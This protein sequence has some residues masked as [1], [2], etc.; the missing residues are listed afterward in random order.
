MLLNFSTHLWDCVRDSSLTNLQQSGNS[1]SDDACAKITSPWPC[2]TE[3]G[4]NQI[5]VVSSST[6]L[7]VLLQGG[8]RSQWITDKSVP[9]SKWS[10]INHHKEVPRYSLFVEQRKHILCCW[11]R[12]KIIIAFSFFI[13]NQIPNSQYLWGKMLTLCLGLSPLLSVWPPLLLFSPQ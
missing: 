3:R 1:D 11:P 5:I 4:L 12:N 13:V 2:D 8:I 7:F 9:S 10:G 6:I